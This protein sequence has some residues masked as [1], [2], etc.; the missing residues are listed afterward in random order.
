VVQGKCFIVALLLFKV[1]ATIPFSENDVIFDEYDGMGIFF[2]EHLV[3]TGKGTTVIAD[4]IYDE[5]G[6]S[7]QIGYGGF[8]TAEQ[9]VTEISFIHT[10]YYL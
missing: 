4:V 6:F 5:A 10:F 7:L 1:A 9:A 2:V 3:G 8:E